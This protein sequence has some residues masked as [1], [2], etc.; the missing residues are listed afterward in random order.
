MSSDLVKKLGLTTRPQP[1]PYHL[2]WF[3]DARKAKVIHTC[4]V[5]FFIGSYASSI[6]C[7]VVPMEA[8]SILLDLPWEFDND[9]THHGRSNTYTLCIKEKNTLLP[10]TPAEI[11]HADKERAASLNGLILKISKLLSLFPHLKRIEKLN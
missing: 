4:R 10:L 6:D 5:S 3:N 9:A 1:H 7:D 11:V 8:C 2:M